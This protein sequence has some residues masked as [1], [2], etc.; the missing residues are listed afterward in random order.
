MQKVPEP[1]RGSRKSAWGGGGGGPRKPPPPPPPPGRHVLL[2]RRLSGRTAVAAAVQALTGEVDRDAHLDAVR[3]GVHAHARPLRVD[4]RARPG[5]T[6]QGI[7]DAVLELERPEVGVRDRRVAA[8]ELAGERRSGTQ[9]RA[10]VDAHDSG[11]E[12]GGGARLELAHFQVDPVGDARPQAG[13]VGGLE[14]VAEGDAAGAFAR[15]GGPQALELAQ[16]EVGEA[17]RRAGEEVQGR[18]RGGRTAP[19]ALRTGRATWS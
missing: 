18:R 15:A 4:V 16:Q 11:V 8:A 19:R 3:V 12:L 1:H 17:P 5:G 13:A 2:Q 9:V 14:G 10:P 6:A 7:D